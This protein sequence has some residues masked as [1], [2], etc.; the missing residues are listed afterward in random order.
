MSLQRR[1]SLDRLRRICGILES[2]L[3]A[4]GMLCLWMRPQVVKELA[5]AKKLYGQTA[6]LRR[7]LRILV[8]QRF[9][10]ERLLELQRM[11]AGQEAALG[12]L[13][14]WLMVVEHRGKEWFS[15]LTVA[16]LRWNAGGVWAAGV[17]A[18]VWRAD[19]A[20]AR[21]LV[22]TGGAAGA[23]DVCGGAC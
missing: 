19:A 16:F 10:S 1:E 23:G 14:R 20:V 11:C 4:Q 2:L 7:G 18:E 21:C 13:E 3:L 12:L 9:Q 15:V 6:I 17:E 22:G 8:A 5:A